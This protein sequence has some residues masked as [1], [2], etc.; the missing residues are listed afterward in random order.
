MASVSHLPISRDWQEKL[1]SL[2][3]VN[4]L[5][6]RLLECSTA[7]DHPFWCRQIFNVAPDDIIDLIIKDVVPD[8]KKQRLGG[9]V[10]SPKMIPHMYNTRAWSTYPCGC[11]NRYEGY[12][13]Q[14]IGIIGSL[15]PPLDQEDRS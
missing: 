6:G 3:A 13:N 11:Q 12:S 1:D 8:V 15:N 2:G 5:Q 4:S 10:D 14:R 9:K 7:V